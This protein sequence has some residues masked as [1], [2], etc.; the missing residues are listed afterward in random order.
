M[1][2]RNKRF[3]TLGFVTCVGE[4]VFDDNYGELHHQNEFMVPKKVSVF[5]KKSEHG[6]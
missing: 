1:T 5:I 3:P 6:Q 2:A 4:K